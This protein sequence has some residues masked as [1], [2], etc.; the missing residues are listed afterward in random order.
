MQDI[1]VSVVMPVYNAFDY[2]RPAMDSV[3]DQTL[4]E[5][6]VICIDDGST[7]HS[8]DILKEY[9]EKDARIRIV[10]ENNAGP[11]TARN[12]GLV[13][14]RGEYTIF[15][16]ADDFFEPDL[17]STL[18]ALAEENSLDIALCE[19]DIYN[20]KHAHFTRQAPQPHEDILSGGRVV[21]K[22]EEP[23]YILQC[24]TGY[25]WNKLFR[26]EFL[27][28]KELTFAPELYVFEDIYFT[29]ATFSLAER[30]AATDRVLVHHRVHSEQSRPRLFRKYLNQIPVV[31]LRIKE[32]LTSHGLYIP[33]KRAFVNLSATRCRMIY[34]VL[35]GDSKA[36]FWD[37][38]HEGVGDS[39]GWYTVGPAEFNS[40]EVCEFCAN[41]GLYTHKQ[42]QKRKRR[43]REHLPIEKI[44]VPKMKKRIRARKALERLLER[45][46]KFFSKFKGKKK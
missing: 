16:D 34:G 1:K 41:V 45:I 25:I 42:Y 13:R 35:W 15:L 26:T 2:L 12:K 3:L 5:I 14:A 40:P 27:R 18:Y 23:D 28:A 44:T 33:L 6:E 39:L 8:L 19:F 11:S 4:K 17:L 20:E 24:H 21:S 37:A 36:D 22:S 38:L 30:I 46:K 32:F 7:D 9:Q 43:G 10:T 29:T 31:Y